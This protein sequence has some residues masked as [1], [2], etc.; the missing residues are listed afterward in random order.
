MTTTTSLS[1][2]CASGLALAALPSLS[3]AQGAT[4]LTGMSTLVDCNNK[5]IGHREKLIADRLDAKLAKSPALTAPERDAWLADIRSLRAVTPSTPKYVP[6]NAKDPDHYTLGLT[7]EEQQSINSMWVRYGQDVNLECEKK[8]GGMLRYSP[9]SDQSG[10][11]RYEDE[12]RSKM[13]TPIDIAT[14]AI[15]ALPSPFPKT[16]EQV[17]AEQRAA[18]DATVAQ[19]QAQKAAAL[20]TMQGAA[21]KMASC[22]DQLKGL[23]LTLTAD[24]MQ[25]K[26][27]GSS[28]LSGKDRSDFEADIK[29]VREAAANGLPFPMPIDPANPMRA[30]TRL[31]TQEQMTMATEYSTKYAQQAAA[32]QSR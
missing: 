2:I 24:A 19:S 13:G 23:Q 8:Y 12:L 6:P 10:Q 14:V 28:T 26:L 25:R 21:A 15:T 29:A 32:C 17:A 5:A 9:G 11:K 27:D 1:W 7:T 16:R 3:L 4:V 30:M 20:A 18:R 22:Q 31:S